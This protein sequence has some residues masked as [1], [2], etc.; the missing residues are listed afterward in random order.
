MDKG[1]YDW[2]LRIE[3]KLDY[4]ITAMQPPTQAKK[5]KPKIEQKPT[6]TE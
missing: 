3:Q 5:E 2:M 4:I 6:A 1:T